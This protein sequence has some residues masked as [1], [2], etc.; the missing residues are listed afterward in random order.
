[1]PGQRR[2]QAIRFLELGRNRIAKRRVDADD[3][4][5][6]LAEHAFTASISAL[7]VRVVGQALQQAGERRL[8]TVAELIA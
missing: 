5:R 8:W 2:V 1:M 6:L 4:V 7:R 3:E